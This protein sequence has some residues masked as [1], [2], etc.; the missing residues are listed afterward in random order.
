[1]SII[2]YK[3][4]NAQELQVVAKT[5]SGKEIGIRVKEGDASWTIAFK[6]GGELPAVLQGGFSRNTYAIQAINTYLSTID[7]APE[8][9]KAPKVKAKGKK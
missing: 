4:G 7:K 3:P 9:K 8:V 6:S 2:T 1:M 5:P